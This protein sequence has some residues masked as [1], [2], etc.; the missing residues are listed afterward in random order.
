MENNDLEPIGSTTKWAALK[1]NALKRLY[2]EIR[3]AV[4]NEWDVIYDVFPNASSVIQVFVI[5]IPTV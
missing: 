1:M 4:V 5:Q 3:V 2:E